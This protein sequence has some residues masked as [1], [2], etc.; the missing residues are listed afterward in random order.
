MVKDIPIIFA[1]LVIRP[2]WLVEIE[3]S[4]AAFGNLEFA[5]Y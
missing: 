1:T 4:I 3:I 2:W 5:M